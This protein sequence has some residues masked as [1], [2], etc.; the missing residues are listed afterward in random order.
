MRGTA[1]KYSVPG[2]AEHIILTSGGHINA[3]A[4]PFIPHTT[5]I[6]RKLYDDIGIKKFIAT[7]T[8]YPAKMSLLGENLSPMNPLNNC[9]APYVM[10]AIVV[11]VAA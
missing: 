4:R 9:P 3:C 7:V 6:S 1:L 2:S 5:A 8:R 11:T 10:N